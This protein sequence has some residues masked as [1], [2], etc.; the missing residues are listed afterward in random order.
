M[1]LSLSCHLVLVIAF[2]NMLQCS[3]VE[4]YLLDVLTAYIKQAFFTPP[5]DKVHSNYFAFGK[6][7][8]AIWC[9]LLRCMQ[10]N[11]Q[12]IELIHSHFAGEQRA[13]AEYDFVIVGSG[14]A[15]C[16]LANRLSENP[17]WKVLLLE[18]GKPET[19]MH[20][21]PAMTSYLLATESNWGYTA[22]PSD[23]FCWGRSIG[24]AM[25]K[26]CF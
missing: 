21:I 7:P 12:F 6:P 18:A 22:E 15:G 5:P 1:D 4:G 19:I 17:E 11:G 20:S 2:G 13:L 8:H 3:S 23:A 10:C 14:P 24:D 9:T 25:E 26:C 16:V